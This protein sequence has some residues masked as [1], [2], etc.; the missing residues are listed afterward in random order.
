MAATFDPALATDKDWVRLLTGD[1]AAPFALQDETIEALLTEASAQGASAAG[2]KY[3]A[4]A[5]AG[6]MALA[7]WMHIG[8]GIVEKQVSK[9]SITYAGGGS[10][11]GA[12]EAY[13]AYLQ[14]LKAKCTELSLTA[15]AAIKAW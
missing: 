13:T 6:S 11:S 10:G 14:G 5:Q 15:P 4:A 1:T 9:L 12:T 2:R 7:H 8:G 3:C